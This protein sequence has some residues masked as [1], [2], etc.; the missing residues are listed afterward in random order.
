MILQR[1]CEAAA[2]FSF[3]PFGYQEGPVEWI[4]DLD[5]DGQ[6]LGFVSTP[7]EGRGQKRGTR[8]HHPFVRRTSGVRPQL[9]ADKASYSLGFAGREPTAKQA[10]DA[11]KQHAAFVAL[12]SHCAE[13]TNHVPVRSVAQFLAQGLHKAQLPE[14]LTPTDVLTFRVDGN[15]LIEGPEVRSCWADHTASTRRGR[16]TETGACLVCGRTR[17][18]ADRMPVPIKGVPGGQ[19]SGCQIVSANAPAFE[20][21]GRK[22]SLVSP[23]CWE[24]GQRHAEVLNAMLADPSYCFRLRDRLAY[25][26]WTREPRGFSAA[27]CLSTP[28]PDDVKQL[29]ESVYSG[30]PQ[31]ADQESFYGLAISGA[32]SRVVVRDWLETTLGTVRSNLAR[33]FAAQST[34]QPDGCPGQPLGVTTLMEALIPS[35]G[36]DRWKQLPPNLVPSVV[37]TALLGVPL[38][39]TLLHLAIAR[40]RSEQGVTQ[41]RA[42]LIRMSLL[43]SSHRE[44]GFDVTE[45]L[46]RQTRNP[47]YLCG[48]LLAV[49]GNVQEAAQPGIKATLVDRFYGTASTAPASVFGNLIRLAQSHL[50]KLRKTNM[51]AYVRLQEALEEVVSPIGE[52][53]PR[54]LTLTD[55]GKFALG[56]YQQR[57]ADAAAR[58]EAVAA[59]KAREAADTDNEGSE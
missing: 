6:L 40:A 57:A 46:D 37:S 1:L 44:E 25:V 56:Y 9:L 42:A 29:L 3:P 41:P 32:K 31:A 7:R 48:R 10:D 54:S 12:L 45:E 14:T 43:L 16:T 39:D 18:L 26:F 27:R 20:S 55:Q 52:E 28:E 50:G 58:N 35:K 15:L 11:R 17:P 30:K 36:R 34:V 59:K 8:M 19:T 23:I 2:H 53:F 5:A 4:I 24:C 33:Y 47:A 21:Y 49:L 13:A 38:R 51:G 22:A